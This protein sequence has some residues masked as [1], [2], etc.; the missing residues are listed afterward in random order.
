MITNFSQMGLYIPLY[1]D[2]S[3]VCKCGSLRKVLHWVFTLHLEVG[4]GPL[5][6]FFLS[7]VCPFI[8]SSTHVSLSLLVPDAV[9]D[10]G[11]RWIK[12]SYC[13]QGTQILVRKMFSYL[14]ISDRQCNGKNTWSILWNHKGNSLIRKLRKVSRKKW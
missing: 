12:P 14:C 11:G 8:T 2:V 6:H 1:F 5:D 7:F 13:L 9:L 4:S 3:L 10:S